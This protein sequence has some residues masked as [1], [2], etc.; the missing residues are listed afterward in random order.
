[1]GDGEMTKKMGWEIGQQLDREKTWIERLMPERD[2]LMAA[3]WGVV[4]FSV[5][6]LVGWWL[7]GNPF[8]ATKRIASPYV[9]AR[10]WV[11]TNNWEIIWSVVAL[12]ML[13]EFLDASAGMGFGTALTPLLLL[14][15]FDPK[16]IVPV[17]MVQQ[18]AAGIVG[19]FLHN[20]FQ[21]VEWKFK[22]MSET[23]RLWL[24]IG[25]VGLVMV[26]LSVTAVYKVLQ[27]PK[28]FIQVYVNALLL[29]MGLV[30]LFQL[31][32]RERKYRPWLM[33][34][35]AGL[36]AFNKGL[37]GGG[38]GPVTTVGGIISGV[39]AKA[40]LAV[41]A[42]SE[43]TVSTFSVLIWLLMLQSGVVIDYILLPSLM[44]ATVFSAVAAPYA[45]RVFPEKIWAYVVP[46]YC[47]IV[48]ALSFYLMAPE[49]IK[50][51]KLG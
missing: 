19:A 36:A 41:T 39:P 27:L 29:F 46:S 18:G 12:S 24:I 30:S 33:A 8:E 31:K 51:L 45:I 23:V 44:M 42:I 32:R 20:E 15:G 9:K 14:I 21:N 50:A 48:T 28:I 6:F 26:A 13:F 22:P 43:G 2:M 16:Q 11:G 3:F 1:M 5:L 17:V 49:L 37:G 35:F 7:A 47:L 10:G 38:Y 40:M 25:G 34:F 4:V